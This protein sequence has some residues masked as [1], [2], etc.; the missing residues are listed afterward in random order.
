MRDTGYVFERGVNLG[1]LEVELCQTKKA[2][3]KFLN[4]KTFAQGSEFGVAII[5]IE[6]VSQKWRSMKLLN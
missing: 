6:L 4:C 3:V 2:F 5:E 1:N